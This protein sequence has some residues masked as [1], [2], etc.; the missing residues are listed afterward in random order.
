[1]YPHSTSKIK[2]P[3][4]PIFFYNVPGPPVISWFI[5]PINYNSY[6]V[7]RIIV[8]IGVINQLHAIVNGG[9]HCSCGSQVKY[10]EASA[11]GPWPK[12]YLPFPERGGCTRESRPGMVPQESWVVAWGVQPKGYEW[13]LLDMTMGYYGIYWIWLWDI[14]GYYGILWDSTISW[15]IMP[16]TS[17]NYGDIRKLSPQ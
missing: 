4:I 15:D 3:A 2:A 10:P 6:T 17:H 7:I 13:N 16:T 14:M 12:V 5:N 8:P 9:P 11:A 1:M